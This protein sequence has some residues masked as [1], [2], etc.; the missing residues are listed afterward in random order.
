M[1]RGEAAPAVEDAR[2]PDREGVAAVIADGFHD[3]PAMRFAFA[4]L[5]ANR[6]RRRL[7][8][9]MRSTVRVGIRRGRVRIVRAAG[10]VAAAAVAYPPE[11]FPLGLGDWIAGG[12]GALTVGPQSALRLARYEQRLK[13]LH[14]A[15]PHYYL[16][17]LAVLPAHRGRGLGAALVDDLSRAADER[18]LACYLETDRLENVGF[19]EARGYRVVEEIAVAEAGG[20]VLHRMV[21]P[22]A[23]AR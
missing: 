9:V 18:A 20:A 13:H 23:G 4:G 21:R 22:P 5:D 10:R 15:E 6:R 3:I 16:Y 7:E 17:L 8:R 19:Y 11:A 1:S 12:L 14:L 2:P